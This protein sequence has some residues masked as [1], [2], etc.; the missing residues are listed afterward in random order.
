[1]QYLHICQ[2]DRRRILCY[3]CISSYICLYL[4]LVLFFVAPILHLLHIFS[5][6]H[7]HLHKLTSKSITW[8]FDSNRMW[9]WIW[10]ATLLCV[11]KYINTNNYHTYYIHTPLQEKHKV[12]NK[13]YTT[14]ID[15]N[16]HFLRY[17]L[18]RPV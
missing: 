10:Y 16:V 7:N 8:N 18:N 15:I 4:V 17:Q 13:H 12:S 3:I 5:F 6:C 14:D 11:V 9:S 1:M 2:L